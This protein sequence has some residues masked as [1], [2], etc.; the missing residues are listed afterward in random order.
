MTHPLTRSQERMLIGILAAVQFVHIIDLMIVIPL[1]PDFALALG[2]PLNRLGWVGGAY[3]L[4]A[5]LAGLVAAVYLDRFDR[6]NAL[7]FCL[8]GLTVMTGLCAFAWDFYSLVTIRFVA[9]LFGGPCTAICFAVV[10]DCIP[11]ERRGTAMGR[12]MAAFS[13]ASILGVPFGLELAR[14]YDWHAPFVATAAA[15]FAVLA[16]T[17]RVMPSLTG[18]LAVGARVKSLHALRHLLLHPLHLMVFAYAS[19]AMFAA[20]LLIPHLASFVQFNLGLPREELGWLYMAGGLGSFTVLQVAGK[21]LNTVSPS[22]V[23]A[24][25]TCVLV[26]VC[27]AGMIHLPHL[28]PPIAIYVLFMSSM[29]VRGVCN[30]TLASGVPAPHQRAGFLALMN[31]ISQTFAA[32]GAFVSATMLHEGAN[33]ALIGFD[34]AAWLAI[35]VSLTVPPMMWL[36]ERHVRRR[37]HATQLIPP[38]GSA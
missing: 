6:R 1:G 35:A 22:K 33:R 4:A 37:D 7:L 20:F 29:S 25:G 9:G 12:V 15:T 23:A 19:L 30:N 10:A 11:S 3:T 27:Y 38:P 31:C 16:F 13:M 24:V 18:H 14:L 2:I 8:S 26:T 32:L 36:V 5:S 17:W 34:R 28:L 21:I